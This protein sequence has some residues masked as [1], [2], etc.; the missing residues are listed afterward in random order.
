MRVRLVGRHDRDQIVASTL[1]VILSS[2]DLEAEASAARA[3]E[4]PVESK[5]RREAA[6]TPVGSFNRTFPQL[7]YV[8][9]WRRGCV[10]SVRIPHQRMLPVLEVNSTCILYALDRCCQLQQSHDPTI[11]KDRSIVDRLHCRVRR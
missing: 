8:Q 5:V 11:E 7:L 6:V 9:F 2:V 3:W 4:M 1:S 10:P